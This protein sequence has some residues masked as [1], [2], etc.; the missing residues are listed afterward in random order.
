MTHQGGHWATKGARGHS[1]CESRPRAQ[2]ETLCPIQRM[3][4]LMTQSMDHADQ[5]QWIQ[6]LGDQL[7]A[8]RHPLAQGPR[9]MLK[10]AR[11][12]APAQRGPGVQGLCTLS[13]SPETGNPDPP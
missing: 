8:C 13:L 4:E 2:S 9:A 3:K 7:L 5:P 11:Q 1:L 10:A 6:E 12:R